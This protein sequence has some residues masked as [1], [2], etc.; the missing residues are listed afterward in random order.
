MEQN[1]APTDKPMHQWST[2]FQQGYQEYTIGKVF[3]ATCCQENWI[4]TCNTMKLELYLALHTK[5]NCKQVKN[6]SKR[7]ENVQALD[8]N[9]GGKLYDIG[10]G[11]DFMDMTPKEQGTKTKIKQ[12]LHQTKKLLNRKRNKSEGRSRQENRRM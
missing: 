1:R 4:A 8:E 12:D 2:N 10:I 6:L 3:S 11:N 5:I 7:P 9:I